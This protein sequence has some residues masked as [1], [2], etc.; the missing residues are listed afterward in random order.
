MCC[1]YLQNNQLSGTIPASLG[2]M[3]ALTYLCVCMR[4]EPIMRCTTE[5]SAPPVHVCSYLGGNQLSGTLP[6]SL[7]SLTGL[8]YLCARARYACE[9]FA[10]DH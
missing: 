4:D 1:S 8:V 3:T 6:A 5:Q 10:L 7:G 2:N 9:P